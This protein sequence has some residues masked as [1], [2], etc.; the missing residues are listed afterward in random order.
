[1]LVL[2][3]FPHVRLRC[4]RTR[5][6]ELNDPKGEKETLQQEAQL[7]PHVMGAR[8]REKTYFT[9]AL[10][11]VLFICFFGV[12]TCHKAPCEC[13]ASWKHRFCS[14]LGRLMRLLCLFGCASVAREGDA[15]S[16][17]GGLGLRTVKQA[18][19]DCG[20]YRLAKLLHRSS[21]SKMKGTA[22]M[23]PWH[24]RQLL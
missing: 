11:F 15:D 21:A 18:V 13:R 9:R 1:M 10:L 3:G 5:T 23:K 7:A 20:L 22:E 2:L 12:T 8:R 14:S 17:A 24:C 4:S 16:K 6:K 19:P